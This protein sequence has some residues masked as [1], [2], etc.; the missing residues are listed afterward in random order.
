MRRKRGFTL[1][2]LLVVIGII[3]LLISILLPALRKAREGGNRI[4]C[5]SNMRQIIMAMM[6]YSNDNSK[7][8]YDYANDGG[9]N[10]SLYPLHPWP[11]GP[12]SATT[13]N[14][15]GGTIYL[16]D[17]HTAIC[18]STSNR[19]ENPDHLRDN[20]AH[21][22]DQDGIRGY[23][24]AHSYELRLHMGAA[25]SHT[26]T[27]DEFPDGYKVPIATLK[28]DGINYEDYC[29]KTQ[30]NSS[31]NAAQNM[32]ITDADDGYNGTNNNFPDSVDNHG[33]QGANVG[34]LDGHVV[35]TLVGRAWLEAYMGGHYRT[36][37]NPNDDAMLAKYG[38]RKTTNS[39]GCYTYSYFP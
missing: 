27:G 17:F 31:K 35:F 5:A 20:A 11:P 22:A 21:P 33:A 16:R 4:K 6:M 13:D 7:K 2:E 14:Q 36:S 23:K 39:N 26:T 3:A 1:V 12:P 15:S 10:D 24:G 28:L 25:S 9:G 30:K 29:W 37:W 38:G 34:F 8:M 32:A 19:C 18:P